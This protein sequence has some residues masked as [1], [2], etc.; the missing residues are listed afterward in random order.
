MLLKNKNAI[1][2]GGGGSIGGAVARAFAREGAKVFLAGCNLAK[3]HQVV[4]D[5]REAGEAAVKKLASSRSAGLPAQF[6]PLNVTDP[7]S[8]A[9]LREFLERTFG[10]LDVL[11]NNAGIIS[12]EEGSGLDMKLATVRATPRGRLAILRDMDHGTIVNWPV[13]MIETFLDTPLPKLTEEEKAEPYRSGGGEAGAGGRRGAVGRSRGEVT[14]LT[15]NRH[16]ERWSRGFSKERARRR[17]PSAVL[18]SITQGLPI[19]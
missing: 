16:A 5:Q 3:L 10:R 11:I 18:R 8:V 7:A 12:D 15:S 9:E 1:I 6:H 4:G 14:W 17:M 19:R 13:S 2:Y